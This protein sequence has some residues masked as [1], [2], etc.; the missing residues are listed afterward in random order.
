MI[1]EALE[2]LVKAIA[3]LDAA[4]APAE[5]AAHVDLARDRLSRLLDSEGPEAPVL[6]DMLPRSAR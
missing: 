6:W 1:T 4:D 5:I 3:L 2:C